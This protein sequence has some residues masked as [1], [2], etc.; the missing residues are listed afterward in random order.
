MLCS[1]QELLVDTGIASTAQVHKLSTRTVRGFW[2]K[3]KRKITERRKLQLRIT[4]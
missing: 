3:K 1:R 2:P 4:G